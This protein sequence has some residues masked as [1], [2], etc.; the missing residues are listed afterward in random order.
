M[1]NV[2][3]MYIERGDGASPEVFDRICQVFSI[4]G[5]GQTNDLVDA[6]TF[7]SGGNREYIAGLADGQEVTLEANYEQDS[8]DLAAMI[9][10]V[11]NRLALNYRLVIGD[12]S[13]VEG[14]G[15]AAIPLSWVINPSVD[16]KNTVSFGLKI[17]GDVEAL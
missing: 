11:K 10:D 4:G 8:L 9:A 2:G 17:S 14:F 7:C 13:P 3:K 15:F 16:D 12:G 6:T 1:A 5:I